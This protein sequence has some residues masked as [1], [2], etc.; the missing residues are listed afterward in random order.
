MQYE[1]MSPSLRGAKNLLLWIY[2]FYFVVK[3]NPCSLMHVYLKRKSAYHTSSTNDCIVLESLYR[4]L[5]G[6]RYF[7]L[8]FS[9]LV[10]RVSCS[11][12]LLGVSELFPILLKVLC[13]L[14]TARATADRI[15]AQ[16]I[17][18]LWARCVTVGIELNSDEKWVW[19]HFLLC[20]GWELSKV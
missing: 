12:E 17:L 9:A 3:E 5:D 15:T 16:Y 6:R 1:E 11:L 18:N 19:R 20:G 10:S 8:T 2:V 7:C 4:L 13:T 14:I